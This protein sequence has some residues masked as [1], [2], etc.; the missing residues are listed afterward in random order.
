MLKVVIFD[1]GGVVMQSP[2]VAIGEY[3]RGLSLPV[4][5]INC[6]ITGR[7]SQ[8]AWAKFER[9]EIELFQF[10]RDF[11]KELSDSVNGNIWYKEYCNRRGL[12]CP[13]LPSELTVDGREL[14]GAMMRAA[15][16]YDQHMR[17][18]LLKLRIAGQHKLV[19]LTNN[20]A[21]VDI[22]VEEATFLGWD[23][24]PTP[25]HLRGLFDDFCDSSSL[26]MRKPE[27]RFY[28]LACER[29]GIEPSEAVF[30]DDI[31]LNL[32]SA[33]ALGMETIRK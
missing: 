26:G 17:H 2:F 1:I 8:G 10:Y 22:P 20:F 5:Y 4:N 33:K 12:E 24:G 9:G 15:S 11:G 3:E 23:D 29:S 19:A 25:N 32:K 27:A 14:F 16:R 13:P 31:G 6:S 28:L 18:A 30:L 7:G 21:R